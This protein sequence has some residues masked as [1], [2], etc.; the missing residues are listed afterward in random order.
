MLNAVVTGAMFGI[1]ASFIPKYTLEKFGY[2]NLSFY[3]FTFSTVAIIGR[4]FF[5]RHID[6]ISKKN[7]ICF[8]LA[9]MFLSL[10][11]LIFLHN[12]E[13]LLIV[14]LFHG[15]GHSIMFPVLSTS[16]LDHGGVEEKAILNNSF[17]V[18][19]TTGGVFFSTFL[20]FVGDAFGTL[21]IFIS[22]S[23]IIMTAIILSLIFMKK[24]KIFDDKTTIDGNSYNED[25]KA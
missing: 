1:C 5:S 9:C 25:L 4:L 19:Y 20:G 6:K 2:S 17:I 11:L 15:I 24:K 3:F 21:S 14:G 10:I 13:M 22:L 12:R 16:F 8:S 23:F 18:F 7:L